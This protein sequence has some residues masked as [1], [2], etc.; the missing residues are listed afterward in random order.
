MLVAL[1]VLFH[2]CV[3]VEHVRAMP[4]RSYKA[5]QY[6]RDACRALIANKSRFLDAR[7]RY[8]EN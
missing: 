8:C 7:L 3:K 5:V 1:R 2:S 6:K 4:P